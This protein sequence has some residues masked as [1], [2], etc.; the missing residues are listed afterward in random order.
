MN[1]LVVGKVFDVLKA[2]SD[3]EKIP[4]ECIDGQQIYSAE[5]NF[6]KVIDDSEEMNA[7]ELSNKMNVTRSAVTQM[8]NKLEERDLIKRYTKPDNKKEKYYRLTK[9][10][11]N[12]LKD[13]DIRHR[14]A[15]EKMCAYLS[16]LDDD[17]RDTLVEFLDNLKECMP[18][19][20]FE[21]LGK[22]AI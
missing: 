11:R 4:K 3:T 6:L 20:N 18:I 9:L 15:N 2:M 14:E 10:G 8:S 16:N 19:T 7:V 21:C 12:V 22:K 17:Q 5:V 1:C 13:N